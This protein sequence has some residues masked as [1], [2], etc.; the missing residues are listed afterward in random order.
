MTLTEKLL[1]TAPITVV[2]WLLCGFWAARVSITHGAGVPRNPRQW[3]IYRMVIA[4]GPLS[5]VAAA[6]VS[7][8]GISFTW[9]DE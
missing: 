6:L 9:G 4:V 2:L 1:I 3:A 7:W 5:F 8:A